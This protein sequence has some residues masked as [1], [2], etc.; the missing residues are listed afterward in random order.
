MTELPSLSDMDVEDMEECKE[1]LWNNV[2]R[3]KSSLRRSKEFYNSKRK[4]APFEKYV[5]SEILELTGQ[6]WKKTRKTKE[7]KLINE[8]M[9]RTNP[10]WHKIK[11]EMMGHVQPL[12]IAKKKKLVSTTVHIS[13][14]LRK[15]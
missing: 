11:Y 9:R 7:F 15:R 12:T 2:S 10:K 3:F 13:D 14:L 8:E 4:V 6:N 5:T 1:V